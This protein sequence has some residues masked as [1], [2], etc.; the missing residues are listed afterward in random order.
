MTG[1]FTLLTLFLL[2]S[3]VVFGQT[4]IIRGPYLQKPTSTS[5]MV[6]WRTDSAEIGEVRYGTTLGSLGNFASEVSATT[7]HAVEITGLS[8]NTQYYYSVGINGS[9]HTPATASYRFKTH[10]VP[11]TEQPIRIWAIG[12]F[13]KANAEERAVKDA[14]VS[15]NNSEAPDIW[16]WLGDNA[17]DDGTDAEFQAKVFDSTAAL[18]EVF[19]YMPFYP[20][21]GNH[22]Y[23]SVMPP[24]T[25]ENPANNDGPY[26]DIVDVPTNGEAGG[27][28]SGHELYYSY[29]IGNVHFVSLNSEI[30]SLVSSSNDWIGTF[31][32]INPFASSF[33]GS[34]FTQWLHDDLSNNTQPWVVAY[35][36]QPPYTDGS[37]DAN[38]FW[39]VYMQAMRENIMP[40][41]ETYDVDLVLCGH[42]HVYERTY[43]IHGH[44]DDRST[45]NAATM[46]VD[47]SSGT[48]SIGEAY[49]KNLAQPNGN[50]G[51]VYAV[52]GNSGSKDSNPPL[53]YPAMYYSYGC[54]TC[55]GSLVVDVHGDTLNGR[56]LSAHGDIMDDFTIYK[57]NVTSTLQP[58]VQPI[59]LALAPNPADREFVIT[60][61]G[62]NA[63]DA[64]MRITDLTGRLIHQ[65]PVTLSETAQK[66]KFNAAA[67]EM[68]AGTYLIE[69]V[70]GKEREVKKLVIR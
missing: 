28:P 40:I 26:F 8:P 46:I 56:Y 5:M 1:K 19:P 34:P 65:Q 4:R 30:G 11:G 2:F 60:F 54:D 16:I 67:L 14:F 50:M 32:L 55:V 63:Q 31:P 68:S 22:D 64:S 17:Y 21:P 15:W 20:C 3:E 52:V 39:E 49:V 42:S 58:E 44:Y 41:L 38:S 10:P 18:G 43:M 33:N 23:L 37:H 25:N 51:T 48:D 29:D 12:D 66:L 24:F 9:A 53:T 45:W 7:E 47:G 70:N 27:T 35:F 59:H 62:R 61:S 69:L 57:T 36:H 13:G 6:R